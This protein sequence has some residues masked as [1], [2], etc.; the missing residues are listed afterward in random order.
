MRTVSTLYV[1][2]MDASISDSKVDVTPFLLGLAWMISTFIVDLFVANGAADQRRA[3]PATDAAASVNRKCLRLMHRSMGTLSLVG[4]QLIA[5][6]G[7]YQLVYCLDFLF[8]DHIRKLGAK[9]GK[10][11]VYRNFANR[12]RG[13]GE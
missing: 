3:E 8:G 5:D 1:E 11:S 7:P 12:L 10:T 2:F 9:Q 6:V 4:H 13:L